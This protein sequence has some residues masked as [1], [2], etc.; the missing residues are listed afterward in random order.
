ML[1]YDFEKSI[2]YWV[3]ATAHE[4]GRAMN[5]ELAAHGITFRQ[6]EVLALISLTGEQSQSEL[7]ERMKIEAPTLVGVLDRMERDGW[8]Q[9]VPDKKDRRRKLIHPTERVEPVWNKMVE[10]ALHTRRRALNDFSEGEID[11]LRG[12]L[13]RM[14]SNLGNTQQSKQDIK[15]HVTVPLGG[16]LPNIESTATASDSAA[17]QVNGTQQSGTEVAAVQPSRE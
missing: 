8:I 11:Q 2:G 13:T 15:A 3:F 9:R 1:Q 10:C 7:A 12:F 5:E 14:R 6:W 16:D 4:F 17:G